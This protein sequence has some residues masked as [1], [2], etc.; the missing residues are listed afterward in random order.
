MRT[1][2]VPAVGNAYGIG[3]NLKALI[4]LWVT[5]SV[6]MGSYGL[7]GNDMYSRCAKDSDDYQLYC[8]GFIRGV[9]EMHA[10]Q[11][12]WTFG[13]AYYCAPKNSTYGQL[14]KVVWKYMDENPELLHKPFIELVT[15]ALRL[16]FPCEEE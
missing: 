16:A 12:H 14:T 1:L 4:T 6:S 13:T 3:P 8:L 7:D 10:E 2:N 5:L 15:E 11:T 9:H